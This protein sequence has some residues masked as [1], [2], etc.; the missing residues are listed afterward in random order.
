MDNKMIMLLVLGAVALF[1]V[2][3]YVLPR[4]EGFANPDTKINPKCPE[5]Y[6][7]CPSGDCIDEKDPHQTC[8]HCT[9]AY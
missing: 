9:D 3:K 6:K 4:I 1:M 5:G 8:G 7:Q 2:V